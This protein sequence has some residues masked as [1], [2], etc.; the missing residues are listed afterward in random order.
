MSI[1][2]KGCRISTSVKTRKRSTLRRSLRNMKGARNNCKE[3]S[4]KRIANSMTHTSSKFSRAVT[5][6]LTVFAKGRQN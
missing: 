3:L 1:M 5:I 6:F 4:S 2:N